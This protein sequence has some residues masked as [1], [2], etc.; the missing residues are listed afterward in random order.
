ML[1]Q[2]SEVQMDELIRV[3]EAAQILGVS[4]HIVRAMVKAGHLPALVAPSGHR[5]FRLQDVEKLVGSTVLVARKNYDAGAVLTRL[6]ALAHE[7]GGIFR[8]RQHL[9]TLEAV[10]AGLRGGA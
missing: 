7:V 5:R 4:E 10:Q 3:G 8:L 1:I 6:A 9:D 2:E